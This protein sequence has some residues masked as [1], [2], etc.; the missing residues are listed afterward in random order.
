MQ[1]SVELFG[2][3]ASAVVAVSLLMS[4]LVRLRWINLTG[5]LMF[6]AY[7]VM[8]R[9]Y[10]VALLNFAIA[11]INVY[12]LA[13]IYRRKDQFRLVELEPSNAV[14]EEFFRVHDG[15]IRRFFPSFPDSV[16]RAKRAFAAMRNGQLAGV[17]LAS[18][19]EPR[20]LRL[21]LDYVVPEYR[22]FKIGHFVYGRRQEVFERLGITRVTASSEVP[23]HAAYLKRMGFVPSGPSDAPLYVRT[24]CG[25][26]ASCGDAGW[27]R[28]E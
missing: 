26:S 18:E 2:F 11:L 22:D 1:N 15:G 20:T 14:L 12:Y 8:I 16:S 7:G 27:R 21:W 13:S 25:E 10:P 9:A 19:T 23:E 4:S 3:C 5:S 24:V 28:T 6:T 17:I